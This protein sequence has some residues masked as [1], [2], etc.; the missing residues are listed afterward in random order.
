MRK[1]KDKKTLPDVFIPS[2]RAE[3]RKSRTDQPLPLFEVLR[4]K[5]GGPSSEGARPAREAQDQAGRRAPFLFGTF[6]LG[7]QRKGTKGE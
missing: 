4:L 1:R 7:E 3:H 2:S 6:S 5:S